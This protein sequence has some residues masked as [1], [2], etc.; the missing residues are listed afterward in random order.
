[1]KRSEDQVT[2]Y[3]NSL[4]DY[5]QLPHE[6]LMG[7]FE[8]LNAVKP[9][10]QEVRSKIIES[11]LRLVVSIAKVYCKCNPTMPMMD[12]IQEGNIGL[13]KAIERFD[14]KKGFHFSTYATW[15]I[16]QAIGQHVFNRKNT[17]RI[18]A[19][20]VNIQKKLAAATVEFMDETGR[21]PTQAELM[22][23]VKV[24]KTAFNAAT[25]ACR[26]TVSLSTPTHVDGDPLE[27]K[28]EDIRMESDPSALCMNAQL[29]EVV[30]K[31]LST[32]TDK[33]AAI[34][35]LRFGLCES[36]NSEEYQISDE[37]YDKIVAGEGMTDD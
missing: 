33:E 24:T 26:G 10:E 7:L 17:I 22:K 31:I 34:I 14:H 35:R 18:P 1:M 21:E 25:H 11:N 29:I 5:P 6:E 32:L 23:R 2:K 16:R 19:H 13:M 9:E 3:L 30:K 4:K 20:A 36:D 12:L 37:D 27:D 15:W 28:I 8:K